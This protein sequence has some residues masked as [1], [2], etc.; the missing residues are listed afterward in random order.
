MELNKVILDFES[1]SLNFGSVQALLDVSFQVKEHEILGIIGPN[2]AGK[3]C[4]LNC[5][6]GFYTPQKGRIVCKG[7][8]I[9]G[10]LPHKIAKLRI[11]RVFQNIE[12]YTGMTTLENLMAARHMLMK[13]DFFWAGLYFGK[14]VRE[15]V[16]H[17]RF[18]EELIDFLDLQPIRHKI[19]GALPYGLRKRVEL[20][21][22]LAM[23]PELMV[24]DEPMAGMN[25]EEK[26]DMTR[27]IM[28]VHELKGTSMIVVEHDMGVV[29]DIVDRIVVLDFGL[30]IAEGTPDEITRNPKVIRA[31][32]GKED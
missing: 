10:L 19:V 3:T 29:M 27:F 9:V 21:R 23:E 4:V 18:V 12:L 5:I 20:G 13:C 2:G 7:Q 22:A 28:D 30:K 32:L 25:V 17:R 24:L 31:Y 16:E 6:N 11:A 1:I 26:E 15:E 14:A 8:N